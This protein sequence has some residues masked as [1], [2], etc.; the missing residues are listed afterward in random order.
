MFLVRNGEIT[1]HL[2][3][4]QSLLEPLEN[5]ERHPIWNTLWESEKHFSFI[6]SLHPSLILI[7]PKQSLNL[8]ISVIPSKDWKFLTSWRTFVNLY[9]H[10]WEVPSLDVEYIQI[11][12]CVWRLEIELI[13]F[14]VQILSPRRNSQWWMMCDL[15]FYDSVTG[16]RSKSCGRTGLSKYFRLRFDS[17]SLLDN[18]MF[19]FTNYLELWCCLGGHNY[20][21]QQVCICWL[22]IAL[23][24]M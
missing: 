11:Q 19:C 18:T 14:P 8:L 13:L 17:L 10:I 22:Y 1:S 5:T 3:K 9:V 24:L 4:P 15:M 21:F 16:E 20:P 12:R 2:E 23:S 6:S 7:V